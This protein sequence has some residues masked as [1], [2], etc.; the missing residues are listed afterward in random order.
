M[1]DPEQIRGDLRRGRHP[2]LAAVVEP[3]PNELYRL[4]FPDGSERTAH[5]AGDLRMGLGRLLPGDVVAVE[6]APFDPT[7]ARILSR[8]GRR[9]QQDAEHRH[10]TSSNDK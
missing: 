5:V 4:R 10:R 2:V 8:A 7:K 6:V 3:L 9:G 1:S